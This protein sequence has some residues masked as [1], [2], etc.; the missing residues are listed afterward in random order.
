MPRRIY[1][2]ILE[3]I[4]HELIIP[5]RTLEEIS[6]GFSRG[7]FWAIVAEISKGIPDII[8]EGIAQEI[9]YSWF[10]EVV[11]EGIR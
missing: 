3:T 10:F 7:F 1:E 6:R 4:W 8:E 2:G 5:T 11:S 9:L